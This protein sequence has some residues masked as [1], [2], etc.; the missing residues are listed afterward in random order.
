MTPKYP[1]IT[2]QLTGSDGNAF[3]VLG[4][5][6]AALRGAGVP[7]A[8]RDAFMGQ[9]QHSCHQPQSDSKW[10]CPVPVSNRVPMR[11]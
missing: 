4:R 2:V 5:V 3:A 6:L 9:T 10:R 7:V 1:N 8:E 11:R